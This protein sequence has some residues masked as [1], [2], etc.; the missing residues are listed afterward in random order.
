MAEA[1]AS[2]LRGG[3]WATHVGPPG[4]RVAGSK[5]GARRGCVN[6]PSSEKFSMLFAE[7]A[8]FARY[9]RCVPPPPGVWFAM[10]SPRLPRKSSHSEVYARS[11]A[12]PCSLISCDIVHSVFDAI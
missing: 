9:V 11:R 1:R 3:A 2:D 7:T 6:A 12:N 8:P 10:T 5:V 4:A